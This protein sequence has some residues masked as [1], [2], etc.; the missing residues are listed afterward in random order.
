MRE[1]LKTVIELLAVASSVSST[2]PKSLLDCTRGWLNPTQKSQNQS[3]AP[4]EL[5]GRELRMTHAETLL[6]LLA[7]H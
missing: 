2:S 1:K 5:R 4:S 3:G 6:H 7:R